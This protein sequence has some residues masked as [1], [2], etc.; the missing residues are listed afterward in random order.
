MEKDPS[1]L[2][3]MRRNP[4][5]LK[6]PGGSTE[7]KAFRDTRLQPPA[8]VVLEGAR[9]LRYHLRCLDDLYEMLKEKGNWVPLGSA[10]E[11][12]QPVPGSVESW[13]R[14]PE[15]PVGGWYGL[16]KGLRGAFATFIPPIM[17]ILN[18]AEVEG[19]ARNGRMRAV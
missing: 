8:L 13:A 9:E 14:S 7:F 3:G 15:N 19:T 11:R 16:V 6:K 4:W 18:L 17:E 1:E 5:V 10:G 2:P 12:E